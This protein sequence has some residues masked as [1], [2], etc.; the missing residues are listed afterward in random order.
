MRHRVRT[1][2]LIAIGT[3][4]LVATI[5]FAISGLPALS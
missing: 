2:A 4:V 5:R 1:V 3:A